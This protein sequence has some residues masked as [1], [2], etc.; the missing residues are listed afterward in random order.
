[1][2]DWTKVAELR[3]EV[4]AQGFDEVIDLF[5]DE[6][7]EALVLLGQVGRRPGP[8][9]HFIQGCAPNL[10]FRDLARLCREQEV[11]TLAGGDCDTAAVDAC[12]RQSKSAFLQGPPS[13]GVA[14]E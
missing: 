13:A 6:V 4:G 3:D 10:G 8:D 14:A 11:K 12:Y 9:L 7:E 2:I 1:M 5:L